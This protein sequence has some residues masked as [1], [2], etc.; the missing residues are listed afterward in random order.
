VT[1]RPEDVARPVPGETTLAGS[2]RPDITRFLNARS[3]DRPSLS[4]DGSLLAFL[5]QMSGHRQVWVVDAQGGWPRQLTFGGPVTF[6]EWSPRGDWILYA[7]DRAPGDGRAGFWLINADGTE[8]R[9]LMPPGE[10]FRLFGAITRDG[11]HMAYATTERNGLDFDLHVVDMETADTQEVMRGRMGLLAASYRPDGGAILL[12]EARGEDANDL[13]LYDL[14]TSSLHTLF[15]PLDRSRYTG[16]SW[17][18]DGRGFYLVTDHER[19][20]AGLAHYDLQKRELRY[21]AGPEDRNVDQAALSGGGRY[22]AWTTNDSGYAGL[23]VRDLVSETQMTAPDL[24]RGLYDIYWAAGAPVAAIRVSGPQIP[25]D[26]WTW[27]AAN[28][29]LHRATRSATAGLDLARMVVPEPHRFPARDGVVLH[30]LLYE[31]PRTATGGKPPV[32]LAV[33]GGPTGQAQPRFEALHQYLLTRG[34]AVFDLNYRGSTGF[35]KA[36]ARL[37]DGR[38]RESEL[39]DLADAAGWL[40]ARDEMDGSRIALMG[41][42][43]GGYLTMAGMTRLPECFVAGVAEVGVSDWITALEG[44]TPEMKACDRYEYGDVD[45]PD[46]REFFRSISP[47]TYVHQVRS[48]MLVVHGA[49]DPQDPV[50][51]SDRF[52]QAVREHGGEVEYVRFPDE[53]HAIEKL[54]NRIIACRRIAAFLEEKLRTR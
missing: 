15:S 12:T 7:V 28:A 1:H 44:A 51:E 17:T 39:Y 34:I 37:N 14:A 42:S 43:Y 50:T 29:D 27:N 13:H 35:G 54:S 6:L 21:V 26:V 18:P 30:G 32:V 49:N 16:F 8:E 10:A 19:D 47:I 24:P 9:E 38:L 40:T 20:F 5:G 41:G 3:V 31:P 25:G 4:P 36:F 23:Y 46:D 48:P 22:L 11:R 52:V 53:G 45:D 33:H 2:D